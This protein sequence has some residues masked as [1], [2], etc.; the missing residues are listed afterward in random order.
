MYYKSTTDAPA[1]AHAEYL[2]NKEAL[3]KSMKALEEQFDGKAVYGFDVF[4]ISFRGLVLNNVET[5]DDAALW[6]KPDKGCGN[7]SRVRSSIRGKEL[8]SQ[9]RALKDKY[10]SLLPDVTRISLD[11]FWNSIGTNAGDLFFAGIKW[12]ELGGVIYVHTRVK[13]GEGMVEILASEYEQAGRTAD[14]REVNHD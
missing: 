7:I 10:S 2:A 14:E 12:H 4:R 8:A 5:R 6:T 1:K 13:L 3:F 11:G 9:L